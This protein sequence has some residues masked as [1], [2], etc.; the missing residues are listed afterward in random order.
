VN[1]NLVRVGH[2]LPFFR[3]KRK[4]RNTIL[5]YTHLVGFEG[6]EFY[7]AVA[8]TVDEAKK[9]VEA[10]FEY[11]CNHNDMMIFRKRNEKVR[12]NLPKSCYK[13]S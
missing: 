7:S 13:I 1:P 10:G 4:F 2:C 9:L 6:D 3:D 8:E 11:V 5:V 12:Y